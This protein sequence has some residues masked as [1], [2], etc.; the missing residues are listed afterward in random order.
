[1]WLDREEEDRP[2]GRNSNSEAASP[3]LGERGEWWDTRQ[4][5]KMEARL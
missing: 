5:Q 1:M 4:E 2:V 3:C